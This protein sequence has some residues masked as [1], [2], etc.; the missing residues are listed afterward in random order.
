[1]RGRTYSIG[2]LARLSGLPVRRIRFY[3]DWGLLPPSGRSVSNYRIYSDIDL[4]RLDLIQSL[5]QTGVEL[6]AIKRVIAQDLSLSEVLTVRLNILERE[7]D[8]KRRIASAIRTI[9][10]ATHA[11]DADLRKILAMANITNAEMKEKVHRFVD[12]ICKNTCVDLNNRQKISSWLA[13][14]IPNNPN[15]DQLQDWQ[16]ISEY[17][18]DENIIKYLI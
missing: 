12:N 11:T 1:M 5:R 8:A 7:L 9:L 10:T 17:L 13:C 18:E 6:D 3:S 16:K 4:A 2:D 14:E 15:S